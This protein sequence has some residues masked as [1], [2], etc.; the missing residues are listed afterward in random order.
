[1]GFLLPNP[2]SVYTCELKM[3]RL[4]KTPREQ[5][6]I[7]R[8]IHR[9]PAPAAK[10]LHMIIR[11]RNIIIRHLILR[12]A[13]L[14]QAGQRH[15]TCPSSRRLFIPNIT[16]SNKTGSALHAA[17]RPR[18][19]HP[20][21]YQVD[22]AQ[23]PHPGQ[24]RTQKQSSHTRQSPTPSESGQSPSHSRRSPL[25]TSSARRQTTHPSPYSGT[26]T[27]LSAGQKTP[28]R[29]SKRML[30]MTKHTRHLYPYLPVTPTLHV[31][32]TMSARTFQTLHR[33]RQ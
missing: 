17:C 12:R 21:R 14:D 33:A 30:A 31:R 15:S 23:N 27:T 19:A 4:K 20:P 29:H 13:L 8:Q 18:P 7:Y 1:M 25:Q 26:R 10:Q 2:K 22:K 32:R 24:S 11:N 3:I 16:A 9:R 6:V 5:R 28:A